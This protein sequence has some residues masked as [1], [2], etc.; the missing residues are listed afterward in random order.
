MHAAIDAHLHPELIG[1][2]PH[3]WT[4]RLPGLIAMTRADLVVVLPE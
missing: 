2:V 3:A 1:G 4:H